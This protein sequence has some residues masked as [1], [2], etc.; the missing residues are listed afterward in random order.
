MRSGE[1]EVKS[2]GAAEPESCEN[3][4][5]LY[6]VFHGEFALFDGGREKDGIVAVAPDMDIHTYS[7][8]AWLGEN[9]VPP[10][11][12]LKLKNVVSVTLADRTNSLRTLGREYEQYPSG[13]FPMPLVPQKPQ[14]PHLLGG[15]GTATCGVSAGYADN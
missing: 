3:P 10:G 5:T 8:G 7:A 13:S 9:R 14:K 12:R 2:R 4:E 11:F 15:G 6:V 1:T